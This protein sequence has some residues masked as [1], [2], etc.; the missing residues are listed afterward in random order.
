ME[1]SYKN[2]LRAITYNS[3]LINDGSED[4]KEQPETKINHK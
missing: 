1:K 4:K 2:L 3:Y